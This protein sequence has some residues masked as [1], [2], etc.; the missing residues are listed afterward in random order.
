MSGLLLMLLSAKAWKLIRAS[1]QVLG[2]SHAMM[3]G[4]HQEGQ[5]AP[6]SFVEHYRLHLP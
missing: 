6:L 3:T 2:L 1:F 4:L 5:E